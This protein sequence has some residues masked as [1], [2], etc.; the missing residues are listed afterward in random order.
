MLYNRIIKVNKKSRSRLAML[1]ATDSYT[2]SISYMGI[3]V[4]IRG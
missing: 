3:N 4:K 2:Y 1:A